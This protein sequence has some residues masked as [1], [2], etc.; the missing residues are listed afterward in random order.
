MREPSPPF[1]TDE[2]KLELLKIAKANVLR[3]YQ[4]DATGQTLSAT[5]AKMTTTGGGPSIAKLTEVC[6]DIADRNPTPY[7]ST[8]SAH[9]EENIM[10]VNKFT[11]IRFQVENG[12]DS[13]S[14]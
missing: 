12:G 14:S 8:T 2:E 11:N 4:A 10:M 9:N 7:G 1:V 6:Q 13:N 5:A 3:Q